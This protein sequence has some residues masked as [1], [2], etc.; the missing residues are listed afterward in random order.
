[1]ELA[2]LVEM[3]EADVVIFKSELSATQVRNISAA[4]EARII[5]R[6]QLILDIFAMWAEIKLRITEKHTKRNGGYE[7]RSLIVH[8]FGHY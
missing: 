1:D 3:H 5:D 6:T 2:A 8:P 4:V 7:V